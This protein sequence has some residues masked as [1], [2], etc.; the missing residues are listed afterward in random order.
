MHN[1]TIKM[2]ALKK[3]EGC[4]FI[5]AFPIL[6]ISKAIVDTTGP[7]VIVNYSPDLRNSNALSLSS[8]EKPFIS[9]F[10]NNLPSRSMILCIH[11]L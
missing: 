11:S 8:I 5:V 2:I 1:V 9:N 10:L 3:T 6:D 7:Q 4:L